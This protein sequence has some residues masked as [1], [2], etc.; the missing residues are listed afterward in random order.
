KPPAHVPGARKWRRMDYFM[1]A[2]S[3]VLV[4]ELVSNAF[5][6]PLREADALDLAGIAALPFDAHVP[7]VSRVEHDAQHP[8]VVR[9][10]LV[11]GGIESI[12][13]RA[14]ALRVRHELGN[15]PVAVVFLG[16]ADRE[17]AEVGQRAAIVETDRADDLR[18]PPP[19]ARQSAVILDDHVEAPPGGE[20]REAAQAVRGVVPLRLVAARRCRVDSN[21]VTS[22]IRRGVDPLVMILDGP[23]ARGFVGIAELAFAVAHDQEASNAL[24]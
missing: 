11:A 4:G 2:R 10:H 9:A 8:T 3:R 24:A 19:V 1:P 20:L 16:R 17:I 18:E 7:A 12:A 5:Q 22:Q 23:T 21:R 14:D 13:L 6:Q 15:A